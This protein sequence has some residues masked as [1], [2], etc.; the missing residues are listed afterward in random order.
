M[1]TAR[2]LAVSPSMHSS[3]RGCTWSH[4]GCEPGPGGYLVPGGV[5]LVPGGKGDVSP[6][7][8]EW[9]T[10]VKILPCPKLCLRMVK[11]CFCSCS[12]PVSGGCTC[13]GVYLGGGVP[14]LGVY[15]GVY[16]VTYPI[17]HLMLPVCCPVTNWDWSPVQLLILCLVMWPV[18]HVGIQPT[19]PPWTEWQTCVKT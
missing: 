4:G 16:H 8:T 10:G 7:W 11:M 13:W 5:H 6:L 3:R 15:L 17:I 18:V 9:Q 12:F 2:L 14:A 19:P 1:R